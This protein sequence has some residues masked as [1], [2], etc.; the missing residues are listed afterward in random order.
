MLRRVALGMDGLNRMGGKRLCFA[1]GSR[2][3]RRPTLVESGGRS[4]CQWFLP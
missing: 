1:V 3:G 2:R 4:P